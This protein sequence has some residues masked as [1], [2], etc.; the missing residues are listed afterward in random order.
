MG[1]DN[2]SVRLVAHFILPKDLSGYYQVGKRQ[3]SALVRAHR[4]SP[5]PPVDLVVIRRLA[6]RA[7][8][9]LRLVAYCI[10]AVM[11]VLVSS[12]WRGKRLICSCR[13]LR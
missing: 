9:E 10:T 4:D 3:A 8:M 7:E 5:T 13:H 1:V 2:A 12:I 11:T 6:E